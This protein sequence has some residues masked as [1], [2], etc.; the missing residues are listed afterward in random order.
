MLRQFGRAVVSTTSS[1]YFRKTRR[2]FCEVRVV[3]KNDRISQ[4]DKSEPILQQIFEKAAADNNKEELINWDSSMQ[5]I[6]KTEEVLPEHKPT[7][8]ELISVRAT[9]PTATL[10]SLI[11]N[12]PTLQ[13]LVDLNIKLDKWEKNG[14]A[15]MALKLDFEEDVLP[16]VDF[17]LQLGIHSDEIGKVL[18]SAP[19]ILETS[20]ENIKV[21]V[22]YLLSKKFS[23]ENIVDIITRAPRWLANPVK[24]LDA[25][26]GFLQ[27]K[28]KL[29]GNEVREV[30][31]QD[32]WA[33]IHKQ[34]KEKVEKQ[35]FILHEEF[36]F[37]QE[38]TKKMM[39]VYP[40]LFIYSN[41]QNLISQFDL[42]HNEAKIPHEL[43]VDFPQ[44]LNRNK[45]LTEG[46]HKFLI[47]L[48]RAQYI[49]SEPNFVSP[50]MLTDTTDEEF[51]ETVARCDI[52]LFHKFLKTI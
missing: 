46:R 48:G 52:S 17:L 32:P 16:K 41:Q 7:E 3:F 27:K 25:K 18:T 30:V 13:K 29:T 5:V 37:T 20:D 4:Q 11:N 47:H 49:P 1:N 24:V 21:R 43:L 6:R 40:R 31:L 15:E 34:V 33:I 2:P 12:S 45:Y 9:R 19:Q 26:L 22:S 35:L 14:Y 10:A 36:G 8:E 38:E 28:L 42:L 23:S 44:A 39:L 50:L 51:C